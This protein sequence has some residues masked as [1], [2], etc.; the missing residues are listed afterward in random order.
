MTRSEWRWVILAAAGITALVEIPYLLAYGQTANN[1]IFTGMLWSPHDFAQYA[2]AM[3][4]GASST[5]WLVH[6]HLT[7]EPHQP[8]F[9]Y[10]LY[11]ALGKLAGQLA[12]DVRTVF[13]LAEMVSRAA[14]LIAIYSFA[15][16]IFSA[17]RDRWL[18]C[19]LTVFSSGLAVWFG[20]ADGIHSFVGDEPGLFATEFQL[21]E[22][23]TFLVFFTA[24]HL[25]LG[26]T[27]LLCTARLYLGAW[28]PGAWRSIWLIGPAVL[29]LGLVNPFS[30]VT[31]LAILA[32]HLATISVTRREL[33]R[34]GVAHAVIACVAAAPFLAYHGITFGADQFWAGTYGQQNVLL[35]P[36]PQYWAF[37]VAPVLALALVGMP[38]FLRQPSPARWLVLV[39]I[40]ISVALMYTPVIIQRRFAFGMQPMW[41][42]VAV[43]GLLRIWPSALPNGLVPSR[44][45]LARCALVALLFGSTAA[46]YSL[47]L[48]EVSRPSTALAGAFHRASIAEA[49]LWLAQAMDPADIVLAETLTGNYLGGIV[50]GRVY[51]GHWVA[52]W[53]YEDKQAAMRQ[54]YRTSEHD[55]AFERFL[56][57]NGIRYV[58]YG[59][60][61]RSWG[62]VPPSGGLLARVY[63]TSEVVIYEVPTSARDGRQADMDRGES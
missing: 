61:E 41:A 20:V 38:A 37:G 2:S 63:A 49:G 28:S 44:R 48:R 39:W 24:P 13:H 16:A 34:C 18:A 5:S 25:M 55:G 62:A 51:V 6:N 47:L 21:P 4:E 59:P 57:D 30:L 43:P 14:L 56:L 35:S 46:L 40:V 11:V 8:A 45:R 12:L 10:P 17:T 15:A 60:W 26:L 22:V 1:L 42:L 50:P 58:V 33:P 53:R 54:F 3:R 19:L 27:L 29:A 52:T 23:S 7:G 31:L 9:M 36:P 32:G